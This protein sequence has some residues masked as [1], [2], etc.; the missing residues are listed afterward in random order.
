MR[1]MVGRVVSGAVFLVAVIGL[2]FVLGMRR[3]S[4]V[5]IDGV[6]KLSRAT[7]RVPLKAAGAQGAYASVVRHVGRKSGKSYETRCEPSPAITVS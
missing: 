5:L 3:R 4:P 7:K 1:A 6:R 2:V